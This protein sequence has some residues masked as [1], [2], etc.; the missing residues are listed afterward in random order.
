MRTKN[1]WKNNSNGQFIAPYET[2][3]KWAGAIKALGGI[4]MIYMQTGFRS[5]DYAEKTPVSSST[6]AKSGRTCDWPA[7][8]HYR[9]VFRLA[10]DG[11]GRDSWVHER[12]LDRGADVSLG[13]VASQRTEG[14]TDLIDKNMITRVGLRWYK[15]R[16]VINYDM[17]GKNPFHA[18]P[19]N[20]DG[21]RAMWTMSY[22]VSGSLMVVASF[23][24]MSKDQIYDLSRPYP[25][26]SERQSARPVDA[27]TNEFP[28]VYD[29]KVNTK[30]HQLTFYNSDTANSAPVGVN[31]AGD[32]AFG[33]LGLDPAKEL[34]IDRP[35]NG[36]AAWTVS[37]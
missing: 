24:R 37:F 19:A 6:S 25:F 36:P 15:N 28:Q 18:K 29:Y 3:K 21:E 27:F 1:F 12:T 35:V 20:R 30:W 7:Y 17:D 9:S 8:M 16:V 31:L 34:S 14:D 32:T 5:L 26:H 2:A 11:L 10:Q 4:P 33:G 22:V 13:L 23:G